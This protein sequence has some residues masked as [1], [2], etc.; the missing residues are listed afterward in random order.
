MGEYASMHWGRRTVCLGVV[1]TQR[2]VYSGVRGLLPR[3]CLPRHPQT[4]RHTT[5]LEPEADTPL[6]GPTGRY[7]PLPR[8]H[9]QTYHPQMTIEAVGAHPTGMHSCL[10]THLKTIHVNIFFKC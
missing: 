7:A 2:G 5:P 1:S 8:T 6:P 9:R 4:Q 10:I 3:G